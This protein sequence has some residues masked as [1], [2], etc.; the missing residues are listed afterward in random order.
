MV[1]LEPP[2]ALRPCLLALRVDDGA[3]DH[4][5]RGEQHRR[6]GQRRP[7]GGEQ[8][9][10]LA[11]AG[12]QRRPAGDRLEG[13]RVAQRGDGARGEERT[14]QRRRQRQQQALGQ[15]QPE[16][17]RSAGAA[18]AVD[19]DLLRLPLA[20]QRRQHH[21]V[22]RDHPRDLQQQQQQRDLR[23]GL[24]VA[25]LGE[26]VRELEPL[27]H[28]QA[29]A[30]LDVARPRGEVVERARHV[31]HGQ[32]LEVG[33]DAGAVAPGQLRELPRQP[34]RVILAAREQRHQA[35]L[36]A[37]REAPPGRVVGHHPAVLEELPAQIPG[38]VRPHKADDLRLEA[39]AH[40]G[41]RLARQLVGGDRLV[42]RERD[43]AAVVVAGRGPAARDRRPRPRA[44][45]RRAARP[46]RSPPAATAGGPRRPSRA[47]RSRR[48]APIAPATAAV[49]RRRGS[50]TRARPSVARPAP[51]GRAS[52]R[53]PR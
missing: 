35:L 20:S 31:A 2:S 51:R 10:V 22:E 3:P 14:E 50:V 48:G 39:H 5:E 30:V 52:R 47:R 29:E 21:D 44:E 33:H 53:G 16:Q 45:S 26:R 42:L 25:E 1:A 4:G 49:P 15:R 34:S 9:G 7:C 37:R 18:A 12:R 41:A 32:P 43:T 27:P 24:R 11:G 13:R 36:W 40:E 23:E 28:R 17:L 38:V 6:E 46:R 8:E 19:C